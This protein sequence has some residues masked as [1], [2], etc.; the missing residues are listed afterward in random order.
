MVRYMCVN[1]KLGRYA[2]MMAREYVSS[3]ASLAALVSLI[4]S[5]ISRL[6]LPCVMPGLIFEHMG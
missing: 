1:S 2:A 5:W 3:E 6:A 4:S